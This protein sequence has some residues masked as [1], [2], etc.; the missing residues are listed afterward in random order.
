MDRGVGWFFAE[1]GEELSTYVRFMAWLGTAPQP[2]R[3]NNVSDGEAPEPITRLAEMEARGAIPVMPP[4]SAPHIIAYLMDVGP[5][6][7]AG[8]DVAAVGWS[9]IHNWRLETATPLPPWQARLIRRLSIDYVIEMRRARD[10]EC[11]PPWV[12][13]TQERRATVDA[14][15]RARVRQLQQM[16]DAS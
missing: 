2:K 1:I 3:G 7:P 10:P 13:S 8:M 9:T 6:E 12:P 15:L 16:R 11:Q 14:K 5:V 4:L